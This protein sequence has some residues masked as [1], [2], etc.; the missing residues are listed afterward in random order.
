[1]EYLDP[2]TAVTAAN[3]YPYYQQ[4]IAHR[5]FYRDERLQC[6]IASSAQAVQEVLTNDVMRVRP[7]EEPVPK[8]IAGTA[9]GEIFARFVRMTDSSSQR[10][11]KGAI[12]GVAHAFDFTELHRIINSCSDVLVTRLEKRDDFLNAFFS[13]L[14]PMVIAA[15][16]GFTSDEALDAAEYTA[17]FAGALTPGASASDI[18]RGILA[19]Q[20]LQQAIE[21]LSREPSAAPLYPF[22]RAGKHAGMSDDD[23]V[24]NALGL[25][26]QS[27]DATAGLI[28]NALLALAR[29]KTVDIGERFVQEVARHDSP[30]QNTR[31]FAAADTIVCGFPVRK[32][33]AILAILAA[34]NRD[35]AVNPH[36]DRFEPLRSNPRTYTFSI[37]VHA[38]P[39]SRIACTI[40]EIGVRRILES[41]IDF[42]AW[43]G[44]YRPSLNARIPNFRLSAPARS[45]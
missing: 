26:F 2:I 3:P 23:V 1:M 36:P 17:Q 35:A 45:L 30:V 27:C 20:S 37:G 40:A 19:T 28:G 13:T 42:T 21:A 5:P 25:I 39:A 41:G 7:L 38:C 33:D 12:S 6:W 16:L 8:A 24:A 11:A 18:Q 44:G 15:A 34:A 14:P 4:L 29:E 22:L 32:G 31:R 10:T 43:S 9:A